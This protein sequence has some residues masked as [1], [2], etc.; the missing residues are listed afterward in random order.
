[1]TDV[2]SRARQ[3]RIAG[4][5]WRRPLLPFLRLLLLGLFLL[6][7]LG[8]H[9]FIPTSSTP[10][11]RSST[12]S[13]AAQ[14][15]RG[16][17]TY[18]ALDWWKDP[19]AT[20]RLLDPEVAKAEGGG[21][22]KDKGKG[23]WLGGVAPAFSSF[24]GLKRLGFSLALPLLV[25]VNA[26]ALF[27]AHPTLQPP[28][29]QAVDSVKVGAC[30]L[31]NCKLEL[32][33]CILDPKCLANVICLQTCNN[34]PDEVGCQIGCGDL[35]ENEVVGQFNACALSKK[36]C[37]PRKEDDGSYPVPSN[38][39]LVKSFDIN[40]FKGK[41]YISAGLNPLFDIFDCQVCPCVCVVCF[42]RCL[43][44]PPSTHPRTHPPNSI[45]RQ[46]TGAFLHGARRQAVRQAQLAHHG[47]GRGV[48]HPG[49]RAAVCAGPGV[50]R[51]AV[52]PRQ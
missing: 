19:S 20:R 33:R 15:R 12:S 21:K 31:Q 44:P 35:F 45:P 1:M 11:A 10:G 52:Q 41:W 49:Y 4:P 25:N 8:T 46:P 47:A 2:G 51:Q 28:A 22:D 38:D 39:A 36:Q 6:Q 18:M 34:R 29:A 23:G 40:S 14:R 13:T 16:L 42:V 48:L 17:P 3:R 32:A 7:A 50:P 37:V 9:A 43:D 27:S 26:G 24:N 5:S 30:L